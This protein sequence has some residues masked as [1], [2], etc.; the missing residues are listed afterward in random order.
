VVVAI[1]LR[2]NHQP[3]ELQLREGKVAAGAQEHVDLAALFY[4][5][6]VLS[7]IKKAGNSFSCGSLRSDAVSTNN[8]RNLTAT[9]LGKPSRRVGCG[10]FRRSAWPQEMLILVFTAFILFTAF[11]LFTV[12]NRIQFQ[13]LIDRA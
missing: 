10:L 6:L 4:S 3:A 5:H 11:T 13:I 7:L 2:L 9:L 1:V 8:S 12:L